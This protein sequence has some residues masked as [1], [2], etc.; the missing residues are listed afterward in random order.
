MKYLIDSSAW[1]EYLEGGEIGEKV[2]EIL[3]GGDEIYILSINIA[4]VISK[5]KRKKKDVEL[6]YKAMISNSKMIEITPRIAKQA[7]ILHALMKK[8]IPGFALADALILK[9]AQT[10]SAKVL[11]ID[12][13]FKNFKEAVFIK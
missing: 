3:Q 2:H 1:I 7:G 6:A 10:I 9:S 11:T 5:V 8:K 13:H 12:R 4:E